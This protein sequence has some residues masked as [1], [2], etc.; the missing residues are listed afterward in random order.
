MTITTLR[1]NQV[2][3]GLDRREVSAR[4]RATVEMGDLANQRI[5]YSVTDGTRRLTV[6]LDIGEAAEAPGWWVSESSS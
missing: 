5:S 6:T 1:F 3:P 4:Y 2:V